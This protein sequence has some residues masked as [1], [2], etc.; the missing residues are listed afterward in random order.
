MKNHLHKTVIFGLLLSF[1]VAAFGQTDEVFFSVPGGFYES[2][3]SVSLTCLSSLHHVRYT[4]N[5]ALPDATS[6]LYEQPLWL[7]ESLYSHSDIYTIRTC[8]ENIFYLPDSVQHCI[9]IRAAVFD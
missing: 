8:P 3:F 4:T 7:D 2:S 5:G 1:S 6:L 9:V